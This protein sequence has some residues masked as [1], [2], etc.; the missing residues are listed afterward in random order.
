MASACRQS[1][2]EYAYPEENLEVKLMSSDATSSGRQFPHTSRRMHRKKQ[3]S[4]KQGSTPVKSAIQRK[5]RDQWIAP[6]VIL[7]VTLVS[8]GPIL[9]N[10]FVEWDDYENLISNAHYR[11]L[12][13]TELRW[14]FTT[15]HMGPYQPLSW[16]TYGLDYLL[17]GMNPSGYHLTSLL[18]HAANAIFFYFVCRRTLEIAWP[19]A[20]NQAP[21]KLSVSA[22]FAALF[23]SIHPLRVE[24]VAWATERRDVVS[25]FFFLAT[26]YCYLRANSQVET[27]SARWLAGAFFFYVLSLLGKATAIT[28]PVVLLVLDFYPLRRVGSDPRSWWTIASQKVW[29]EKLLFVVPAILFAIVAFLGQQHVTALKSLGSYGIVSRVAQALFAGGFYC[30]KTILPLDLSPLY[31]I[32]PNFRF[33]DPTI[34]AGAALTIIITITVYVLR[35]RSPAGVAC[36]AYSLALLAPVLGLVSTGPQLAAD[37]YTYLSFLS[38][39]VL[40]GGGLLSFTRAVSHWRNTLT[41]YLTAAMIVTVLSVLTWNQ[42]M[43]WRDTDTLWRHVLKLNPD[44]SIAH[45]N[46]ARFLASHGER[47]RAMTHYRE[48]LNIRPNDAEAHNNLGLLLALSG[49]TEESLKEFEAAVQSAPGYAKAFFN[50]G[51]VYASSGELD[52]AVANYQ[53][54]IT[55]NPNEAEI[56]LGLGK[57]LARQGRLDEAAAQLELAMRLQPDWADARAAWARVLEAQGKKI[58]A[59]RQYEEALRLLKARR[60]LDSKS[61]AIP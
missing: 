45:Y 3:M 34:L 24:S 46:L 56:R 51:R 39:A 36:W 7:T 59:E 12:G 29:R 60:A 14:M 25:G 52:K 18:F 48:A 50:L 30:W 11:G 44:S 15:V 27:Q 32:P 35:K 37:R 31:E 57:A 49:R 61:E 26:I 21:W 53:Q 43:V 10:Q 41:A 19:N 9:R 6:I 17:W 2:S 58:E 40:A 38:W 13:W 33:W 1:L 22:A 23:F 5:L 42:T 54:A 20:L 47:E 55:L 28:L 16:M 8:F 4:P